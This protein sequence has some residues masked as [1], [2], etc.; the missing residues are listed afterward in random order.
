MKKDEEKKGFFHNWIV[1][2]LLWAVVAI[3]AIL[4]LSAFL[5]SRITHH[6]KVIRVPD[7]TGMT[8]NQADQYAR[9][10]SL[11]I[12]IADS[13]FVKRMARGAV[14]SQNPKPG[15]TVKTGR[16][17][18]LTI[19]AMNAKKVSMPNLVGYSMR[20][21]KAELNSRGLTLGRLLYVD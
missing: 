10:A 1:K 16:R 19:N 12:D 14:F 21:A 6:G 18:M 7:F 17:V 3:V 4:L 9:D 20:Q 2:N 5:L 13:V 15:A 8:V 11:R